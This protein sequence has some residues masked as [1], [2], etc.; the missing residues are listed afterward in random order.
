MKIRHRPGLENVADLFTKC[1]PSK[2]F[3]R[4]RTTLGILTIDAPLEDLLA[5]SVSK[6]KRNL[7]VVELCCRD[8]SMIQKACETSGFR[9][10]GVRK[11]VELKSVV[12][13]VKRFVEEQ[14]SVGNWVHLHISTPC[15]SGSPLKNLSGNVE[16]QADVEWKG[17]MDAI[18]KYLDEGIVADSTSFELPLSNSIW[19]RSE[20]KHVL[21]K[22]GLKFCQDVHL[23]QAGYKGKD[24]LPIGKVMR[25]RCTHEQFCLSLRGRFG[26]CSC[27]KH[28]PLDQVSWTDTG[29]YNKTLA[30]GILNGAKANGK[31]R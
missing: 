3:L 8:G 29:F 19:D 17:I 15:T 22:G 26:K 12:L 25:F 5:L 21:E 28:S 2:D 20:T 31:S 14:K 1:L 18:P 27:E 13:Q 6:T 10:C 7:A 9:Y 16:T 4:H 11:D 24:G 23:C 30:R